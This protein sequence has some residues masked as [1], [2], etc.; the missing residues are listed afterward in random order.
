M[1][2]LDHA[3]TTWIS[4]NPPPTKLTELTAFLEVAL[5]YQ[6]Q[7]LTALFT[8]HR[9]QPYLPTYGLSLTPTHLL[10]QQPTKSANTHIS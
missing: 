9:S 10:C 7:V 3:P 2:F 6:T 5:N 1:T 4:S 8:H